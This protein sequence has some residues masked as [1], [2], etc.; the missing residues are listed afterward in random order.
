MITKRGQTAA[1]TAVLL[2]IIAGFLIMFIILVAPEERARIL[3]EDLQEDTFSGDELEEAVTDENLLTE[4]PGKID[5]LAQKEVE[6]PLPVINVFTKTESA[7][8]AEKNVGYT[9]NGVFSEEVSTFTFSIKDLENTENVL[10]A[11]DADKVEG[12]LIIT[13]NEDEVF[14]AEVS[15]NV[16]PIPLPLNSLKSANTLI[17][18]VSS[19]GIAFWATNEASLR[20]MRVVGDITDIGAKSSKNIFLVSETE[21]RNLER[22]ILKFQPSC[23]YD[24]VGPLTIAVNENVI[25][26]AVP[27]CDIAFIPIEFSPE[28]INQG[29]NQVI[30]STPKG[31]YVLSHV[32]ITSEL[33]EVDF[34]TYYFE[35]SEEQY[36]EVVDGDRKIRLQMDF[37][38][39]RSSKFGDLIFNGH[40]NHFD[41]RE[42]TFTL[43]LSEDIVRGNNALK[44]KPRRTLEVR[45]LNVDLVK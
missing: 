5:Y 28:L 2:A 30:F 24:E 9:K 22:V 34:P 21:K 26:E 41:T 18:S 31:T 13:L 17:F 36:Q 43:D 14:N 11:L 6:H 10:L 39:V 38:D 19:P 42:V 15:T 45:Q 1:G 23:K 8:I 35:L 44:I 33:T 4:S 40:V 27:D 20:N 29:E 37:V 7:V 32:L 16:P 25:Y 3:G 12:R